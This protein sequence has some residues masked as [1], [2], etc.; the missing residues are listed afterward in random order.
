MP[1]FTIDDSGTLVG[2][3]STILYLGSEGFTDSWLLD[4]MRGDLAPIFYGDLTL[5]SDNDRKFMAAT[6]RLLEKNQQAFANTR[7]ILGFPGKGQVY[8]YLSD[9]GEITFLTVVNPALLPQSFSLLAPGNIPVRGNVKLLFSNDAQARELL[10]PMQGVI[11]GVLVPGEIRVYALGSRE[12][13]DPL[14]LPPAPTRQFHHVTPLPDLFGGNNEAGLTI[15]PKRVGTTLAVIIQYWKAGE[16][17]R[18]FGRPQEVITLKGEINST[19]VKFSSIPKEGSDIWSRCSW[20]VFK[21]PISANEANQHLKL[22]LVGKPP[23]E[24]TAQVT[25]LWLK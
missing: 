14:S 5:L 11:Q 20:A 22:E 1:L 12:R 13:L 23:A 3:T 9:G 19:P 21:H 7:P 16:P 8:G 4:I 25:A 18:S 17:D 15:D 6:L 24:T 2:K 10:R